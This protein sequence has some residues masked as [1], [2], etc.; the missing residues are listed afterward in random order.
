MTASGLQFVRRKNE[1]G[2]VYFISN[3]QKK[4]FEGWLTIEAK[5]KNVILFDP[6]FE[7]SGVG[8]SRLSTNDNLEFYLQLNAGE[9]II[10]Q[11]TSSADTGAAFF[12]PKQDGQT[13][14]LSLVWKLSFLSGG[15]ALPKA[16]DLKELVSWTELPGNA[17]KI[18]SGTA[19]YTAKFK[20]PILNSQAW[21]L[22]L[23]AVDESAEVYLNKKKLGTLIGPSFQ[24]IIPASLLLP[25]NLLEI[26]V[27]NGM[28]NRIIDLDKRGVQWKKFYNVNFPAGLAANRGSDGLFTAA[29]WEP[30]SSGLL[31][32]VTLIPVNNNQ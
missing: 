9:S 19:L 15:P 32:P 13:Q 29:K 3:P 28:A 6:M 11:T 25:A 14:P 16:V 4:S 7:K 24:V 1:Q 17:Y 5:G 10:V 23:G 26:K 21:I 20:K 30:R 18:F 2:T 8:R 27:T 12:Y 31:G 22:D